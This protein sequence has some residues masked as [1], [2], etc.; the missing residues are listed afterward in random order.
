MPLLLARWHINSNATNDE[1][2]PILSQDPKWNSFALADM[3]PPL[4]DYS[5]FVMASRM[6]SDEYTI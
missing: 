4:H 1:A 3:E 5:Q 2:Y 6:K